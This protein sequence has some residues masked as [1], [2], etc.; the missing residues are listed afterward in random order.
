MMLATLDCNWQPPGINTLQ[1]LGPNRSVD[2]PGR[3]DLYKKTLC[4]LTRALSII[5]HKII[6][7]GIIII[8]LC[9]AILFRLELRALRGILKLLCM[10]IRRLNTGPQS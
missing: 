7:F 3:Q 9:I 8:I 4:W 10:L 6:M 2:Q 5:Y 1:L